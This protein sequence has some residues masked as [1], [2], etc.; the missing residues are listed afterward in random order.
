MTAADPHAIEHEMA[1]ELQAFYANRPLMWRNILWFS[2]LNVGWSVCFTIIYPL[3]TLRM[4]SPEVGMGEGLIGTIG[5]VNGYAVSFLV[6]Y[7][8]WKS[9]H[10]ISRWGRRIPFLWISA[11]GIIL[12]L[13]LFPFFAN[14]WILVGLMIMQLFFMDIKASTISLL[15]IDLAPRPLLARTMAIQGVI[16]GLLGFLV[17][18]YGMQLSDYSEKLPFLFAAVIL[19][20]S[21]IVGGFGIKEPPIQTPATEPFKPWSA[22]QVGFR[23]RRR[24]VLMLSVPMIGATFTM[25]NAWL[26][27]FAKN[28]LGLTRTD[29]GAALSWSSLLGLVLSMPYA[30]LIDKINPYKLVALG[31]F[32]QFI[33]FL[34]LLNIHS[35]NG[36]IVV[37]FLFAAS[38]GIGGVASIVVFRAAHP[39]EVGSV[40]SC[41]GFVNNFFNATLLLVSGQLIERL[42][43]NYHAA[44]ILGICL[45]ALGFAVLLTYRQ[46]TTSTPVRGVMAKPALKPSDLIT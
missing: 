24:I 38:S 1:P 16:L 15:P 18:R 35:A 17:L 46:L 28:E 36:L 41:L 14:K 34:A 5:S 43:H 45:S 25:Y 4:N 44:Y 42:G 9:D 12:P 23:D 31:L 22:L 33:L 11:P 3:I 26:W 7:F 37:S 21:T 10:T 27:L 2:I 6:M 40:T 8:S 32:L 20:L 19:A 30:W 29:M 13:L 39:A